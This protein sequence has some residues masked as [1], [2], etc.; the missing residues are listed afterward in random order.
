MTTSIALLAGDYT[1]NFQFLKTD[2]VFS[3]LNADGWKLPHLYLHNLRAAVL[4]V[5]SSSNS[6]LRTI[7]I[8]VTR[9]GGGMVC[10]ALFKECTHWAEKGESK[11]LLECKKNIMISTRFSVDNFR[12]CYWRSQLIQTK[13]NNS[14]HSSVWFFLCNQSEFL[15]ELV[16]LQ[17]LWTLC[18]IDMRI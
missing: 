13:Q 11:S 12:S 5:L 7:E 8:D 16:R 10:N 3:H 2:K 1:E 4:C 14:H 6:E 17:K 18:N 15:S 9:S